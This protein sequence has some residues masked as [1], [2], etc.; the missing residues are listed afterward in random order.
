MQR[1]FAGRDPFRRSAAWRSVVGCVVAYA[2]VIAA[3]LSSVIQAEW[4]AQ[5]VAGLVGERCATDARAAGMDPAAPAGQPHDSF[6]CVL[7]TVAAGSAV[8]PAAQSGAPVV[9]PRAGAPAS[10]SHRDLVLSPGHPGKLPR[11]PPAAVSV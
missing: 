5:A 3:L 10:G 1:N 4:V 9:L 2:L 11:G 7:C 6:H 8:L